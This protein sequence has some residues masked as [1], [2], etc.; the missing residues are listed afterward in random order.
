MPQ[1]P[2]QLRRSPGLYHRELHFFKTSVDGIF[3]AFEIVW[4]QQAAFGVF[5]AIGDSKQGF[6]I[7]KL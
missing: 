7:V 5:V 1:R 3:P 2:M 6:G 4:T